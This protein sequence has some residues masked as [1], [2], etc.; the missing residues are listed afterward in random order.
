MAV[1]KARRERRRYTW[2]FNHGRNDFEILDAGTRGDPL[3][4]VVAT[5]PNADL[6]DAF[7]MWM[8][9]EEYQPARW[10]N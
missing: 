8:D 5:T 2:A 9:A 7:I 1:E 10:V 4:D 3:C 6:R